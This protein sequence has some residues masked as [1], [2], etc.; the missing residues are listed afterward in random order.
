MKEH[1]YKG[2]ADMM[3]QITRVY[4]WEASTQE[5]DDW[6]F[7][8]IAETFVID[9]EMKQFFEENNPHALEEIARRLLEAE[10]R[11][12]WD[13]KPEVLEDLRPSYLEIESWMEER[14]G[15]GDFQGG[16]VNIYTSTDVTPWGES[17]ADVLKF[18]HNRRKE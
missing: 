17:I 16:N 11:G 1:G 6:I 5:V 15:Q 4:G 3:K 18:I 9:P 2:A 13:A 7:D 8:D 10:Q 12:L 14:T